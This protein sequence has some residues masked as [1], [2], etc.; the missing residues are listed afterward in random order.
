MAM[1]A[2][3]VLTVNCIANVSDSQ[4]ISIVH[5][6]GALGNF[7]Y[8]VRKGNTLHK[9]V[10]FDRSAVTQS[11]CAEQTMKNETSVS[12]H[13]GLRLIGISIRLHAIWE[14]I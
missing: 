10:K 1:T 9:L 13:F 7:C 12:I 14:T 11:S 6:R 3:K 4:L 8:K 5:S 2:P